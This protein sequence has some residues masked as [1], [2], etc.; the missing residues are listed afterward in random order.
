MYFYLI[1][2]A[3]PPLIHLHLNDYRELYM[4]YLTCLIKHIFMWRYNSDGMNN[5]LHVLINTTRTTYL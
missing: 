2:T 4:F 5:Q 1:L 3:T